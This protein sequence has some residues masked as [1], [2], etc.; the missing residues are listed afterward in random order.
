MSQEMLMNIYN[1]IVKVRQLLEMTVK[2]KIEKEL[3]KILTTKERKI[4]WALSDGFTDT[5]AI[6][7]TAGISQRSVQRTVKELQVADFLVVERRGYPRRKFNYVP[8]DWTQKVKEEEMKH[9]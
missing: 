9:E 2:D 3:E 7:K 6:A 1:E 8:Y 5:K 4:V